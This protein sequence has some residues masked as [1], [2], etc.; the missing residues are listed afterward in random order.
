M[1]GD[2]KK[3]VDDSTQLQYEHDD[4]TIVVANKGANSEWSALAGP[5]SRTRDIGNA[6][7]KREAKKILKRYMRRHPNGVNDLS[8]GGGTSPLMGGGGSSSTGGGDGLL[9]GGGDNDI[10]NT[11]DDLLG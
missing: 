9:E 4:G 11:N 10:L 7:T 2:Y 8:S 3:V 5:V 6:D 1:P